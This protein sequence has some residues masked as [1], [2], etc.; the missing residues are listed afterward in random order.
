MVELDAAGRAIGLEEKP[1]RPRS[2]FAVTGLY[3]YDQQVVDIAAG[4]EPSARGELEIT[5]VNRTY[6]EQ[7][8]LSVELLGRGTAWLDT[9]TQESL[10][11]AS[12]YVQ[13]IEERQGTMIGCLEEIAFQRG[14]ISAD[15][16]A[17]EADRMG[18]SRYGQYLRRVLDETRER[19]GF[20]PDS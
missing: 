20:T 17:A 10:M 14:Y 7:G 1:I 9:G 11:Q 13:A 2:P 19:A 6:L 5:D 15:D 3:F 16:L 4:L 18:S 12:S 8:E